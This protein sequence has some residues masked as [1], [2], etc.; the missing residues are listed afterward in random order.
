MNHGLLPL[1]SRPSR[2]WT[3]SSLGY[4]GPCTAQPQLPARN[5]A[6]PCTDMISCARRVWF[7][8][9]CRSL[10]ILNNCDETPS[11][12]SPCRQPPRLW[13]QRGAVAETSSS[14]SLAVAVWGTLRLHP[15]GWREGPPSLST[16]CFLPEGGTGSG[17]G[18]VLC[19]SSFSF[20]ET[21]MPCSRLYVQPGVQGPRT[22]NNVPM[23]GNPL[24]RAPVFHIGNRNCFGRD[25]HIRPP[26]VLSRGI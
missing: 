10:I 16:L 7:R 25:R 19:S 20:L 26:C 18:V 6:P 15:S 17:E 4:R 2:Q 13:F 5:H 14:L 21:H 23:R 1:L 12:Q 8:L 22:R 11:R 9:A 3:P 24:R